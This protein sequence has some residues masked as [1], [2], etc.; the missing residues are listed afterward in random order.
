MNLIEIVHM[1]HILNNIFM[2]NNLSPF[3]KVIDAVL[4]IMLQYP[5]V[6]CK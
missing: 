5:E 6:S 2:S 4:S 3:D 1:S